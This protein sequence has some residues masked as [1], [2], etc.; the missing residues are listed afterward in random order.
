MKP[1]THYTIGSDSYVT[2][3]KVDI[4]Y[5][6]NIT[7]HIQGSSK[8]TYSIVHTGRVVGVTSA[9]RAIETGVTLT[10]S[11]VTL[12]ATQTWQNL[13]FTGT[14]SLCVLYN[15]AYF[16]EKIICGRQLMND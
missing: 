7:R 3:S 1:C 12:S 8:I 14:S 10:V 13:I 6:W 15:Y 16:L 11:T 2:E 4:L 5:L 9:V